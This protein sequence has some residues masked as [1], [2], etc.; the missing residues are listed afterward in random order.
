MFRELFAASLR[1]LTTC[2]CLGGLFLCV[3]C[4]QQDPASA[5][6]SDTGAAGNQASLPPTERE[7]LLRE[8]NEVIQRTLEKRELNTSD[9]AAWQV[10]HGVLAYGQQFPIRIGPEG[11]L[12]PAV[13]YLLGGGTLR[14]WDL[15]A[16]DKLSHGRTGLRAIMAPGSKS[17]QGHAD[18]WLA[19]L[20]QCGL[21]PEQTIKVTSGEY[22]MEDLIRQVQWDIPRNVEREWS[23]TL[24]ALTS[25]LPTDASWTAADGNTWSIAGLVEHES[26]QD[27][28]QSACG[29][30]HR[31]IGLCM[32]LNRHLE[33]G[34]ELEG[35]WQLANARIEESVQQA[36]AFQSES[37]AL[38]SNYFE[39]PGVS[40]DLAQTLSTSGHAFEFLAFALPNARLTEGWVVR[41]AQHLCKLFR[42]T[43]DM[44]L[45]CGSLYH[46]MHGLVIYRDRLEM[47]PTSEAPAPSQD[48][49]TPDPAPPDASPAG[50]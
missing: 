25:Y 24:I 29:G 36:R 43:E 38:S 31:L 48:S 49:A 50:P 6:S 40:A 27:L 42:M 37:G 26:R 23:W 47:P 21:T 34:G 28:H 4:D 35:S 5:P 20:A 12:V 18:Q 45:E 41:S 2:A 11:D 44:A 46:A 15:R 39:R 30:T 10:L 13:D 33:R 8:L 14:G 3:A 16:G 9:H 32:A 19:V 7:N 22:L 1:T 17:G